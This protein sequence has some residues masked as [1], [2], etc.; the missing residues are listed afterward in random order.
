MRLPP[1]GDGL[2]MVG[3]MKQLLYV[4]HT[5]HALNQWELNGI[6]SVS[7]WNNARAQIT[8][9]LLHLDGGFLQLLEGPPSGIDRAF[10]RIRVDTRHWHTK[11]LSEQEAPRLFPEWTMGFVQPHPADPQTSG[12]HEIGQLALSDRMS[13]NTANV[14]LAMLRAYYHIQADA[15][16]T[17]AA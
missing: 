10:T 2:P 14:A 16:F 7:R 3:I 12:L 6:L 4:S 1:R 15:G 5:Q 17:L 8:G 9:L 11:I 13:P